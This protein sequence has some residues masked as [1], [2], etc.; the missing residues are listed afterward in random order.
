MAEGCTSSA[1]R[2]EGGRDTEK[3]SNY[4]SSLPPHNADKEHNPEFRGLGEGPCGLPGLWD[5]WMEKVAQME[6][7]LLQVEGGC[8]RRLPPPSPGKA[9]PQGR[10]GGR[11]EGW[12]PSLPRG[13]R[14]TSGCS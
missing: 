10:R 13:A 5:G 14:G 8:S 3:N 9:D 12:Q 1:A 2:A 7:V 6:L 4:P 11:L